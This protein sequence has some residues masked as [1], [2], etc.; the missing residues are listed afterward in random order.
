MSQDQVRGYGLT[1]G[2]GNVTI[3]ALSQTVTGSTDDNGDY[4]DWSGVSEGDFF[5]VG[6]DRTQHQIS[7]VDSTST[8]PTLTLSVLYPV[9]VTDDDEWIIVRYFTVNKSLPLV[10]QGDS[11]FADINARQ[12][13]MIDELLA[14]GLSN[15]GFAIDKL[16]TAPG[17]RKS[18]V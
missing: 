12:M 14:G 3:V 8:P 16:A 5:Q 7:A 13:K 9:A 1:N 15:Q 6:S 11:Y 2:Q 17:D 10:Q 18:V 4:P